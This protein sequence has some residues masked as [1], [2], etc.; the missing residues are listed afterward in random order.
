MTGLNGRHERLSG[1]LVLPARLSLYGAPRFRITGGE[2]ARGGDE[3]LCRALRLPAWLTLHGTPW[4]GISGLVD[5][6]VRGFDEGFGGALGLP[7]RFALYGA[8][9]LGICDG[10]RFGD[11]R[12]DGEEEGKR[13]SHV[14]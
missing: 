10:R 9:R 4:L 11:G 3:G 12:R 13:E 14:G 1:S 2:D 8:P 7:A 5:V 6:G